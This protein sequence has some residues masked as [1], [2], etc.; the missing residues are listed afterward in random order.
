KWKHGIA[1]K[2]PE[3]GALYRVEVAILKDVATLT[4]DTSGAG[5]H[6][7]GYRI[8]QGEAPLKETLAAALVLLTNWRAEEPF[9]DPF[10][11]SGTIPIEAALIGQNI[12]PGF[13]REFA[14]E[15]WSFIRQSNGEKA[16]DEAEQ[17][18]NYD[19]QL[20]IT[21]SDID[22]KMI[23][24]AKVN[25]HEAGLAY[26]ITWKLMQVADI[27]I[28]TINIYLLGILTFGEQFQDK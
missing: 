21:G 25:A 26:L 6:K 14:S 4:L 23:G 7:R 1:G 22:H 9:I 2:L 28:L 15:E 3:N 16:F 5:L 8:G 13:N 20:N 19:Q 17:L 11:G 18:S 24:I 10:C 27:S 12:A